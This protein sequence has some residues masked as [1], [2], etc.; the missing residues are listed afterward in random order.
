MSDTHDYVKE[1]F[2]LDVYIRENEQRTP[3]NSIAAFLASRDLRVK[4]EAKAEVHE[5]VAL[6]LRMGIFN[7]DPK[8]WDKTTL[9]WKA[10]AQDPK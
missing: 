8:E 10:A 7:T 6:A 5:G 3:I 9:H 2:A 1:A 4:A